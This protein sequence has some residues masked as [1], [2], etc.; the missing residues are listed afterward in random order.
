MTQDNIYGKILAPSRCNWWISEFREENALLSHIHHSL[1]V[2]LIEC[3]TYIHC[4]PLY[5]GVKVPVWHPFPVKWHDVGIRVKDS[6]PFPEALLPLPCEGLLL[7]WFCSCFPF[8]HCSGYLEYG[9][10]LSTHLLSTCMFIWWILGMQFLTKSW[11]WTATHIQRERSN[12]G[13]IMWDQSG[14]F[15]SLLKFQANWFPWQWNDANLGLWPN[16]HSFGGEV[17]ARGP[18]GR[19][20][21]HTSSIGGKLR[22]CSGVCMDIKMILHMDDTFLGNI[23]SP[24]L[25]SWPPLPSL[26]QYIYLLYRIALR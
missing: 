3:S 2:W 6:K 20:H 9:S 24:T 22:Y 18:V 1:L 16:C 13:E 15:P 17:H 26:Y 12:Y 23:L 5:K 10:L 19:S 14:E 11:Y 21:P 8:F 25:A 7:L 4:S